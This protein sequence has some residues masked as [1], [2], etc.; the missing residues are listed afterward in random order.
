[1]STSRSKGVFQCLPPSSYLEKTQTR[2]LFAASEP[3]QPF[4]FEPCHPSLP[5]FSVVAARIRLYS[6]I[7]GHNLTA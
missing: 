6:A 4:A 2:F 1:M 3:C 7:T 5:G